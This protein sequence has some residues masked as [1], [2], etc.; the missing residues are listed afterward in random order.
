VHA[1]GAHARLLD[2]AAER[3]IAEHF[4]LFSHFVC[5]MTHCYVAHRNVVSSYSLE[6]G[7]FEAHWRFDDTVT[8]LRLV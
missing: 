1:A 7:A 5:N 6:A 3:R 4:R 8:D 2:G